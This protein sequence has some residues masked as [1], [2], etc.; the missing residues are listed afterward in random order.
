M[1]L[2]KHKYSGKIM[3][4]YRVTANGIHLYGKPG[5]DE[6]DCSVMSRDLFA[7][8]WDRYDGPWP[9]EQE[10]VLPDLPSEIGAAEA[11]PEKRGRGRPKGSK[12]RPKGEPVGSS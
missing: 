9:I 3:E 12:N 10:A 8:K 2:I 4:L 11:K 7:M 1:N 5:G 6:N